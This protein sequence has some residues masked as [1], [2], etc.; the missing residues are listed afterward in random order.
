MI[1]STPAGSRKGADRLSSAAS[2]CPLRSR[3]PRARCCGTL[4][5]DQRR[6][7][8]AW[9]FCHQR[10]APKR[11]TVG[12]AR[13]RPASKGMLTLADGRAFVISR[14]WLR[15][16]WNPAWPSWRPRRSAFAA[17]GRQT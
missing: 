12:S 5:N 6:R 13:S 4:L 11:S 3:R 1:N 9:I 2:K 14:C 8:R 10:R 16:P 17:T 7:Q 15:W